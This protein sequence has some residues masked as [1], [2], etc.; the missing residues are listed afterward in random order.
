MKWKEIIRAMR[1][2]EPVRSYDPYM[3]TYGEV[4]SIQKVC[5]IR[6]TSGKLSIGAELKGYNSVYNVL[7]M[8]VKPAE[9]G[10]V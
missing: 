7:A 9:E 10:N 2:N 1:R 5:L 6:R 4:C 3:K 8:N